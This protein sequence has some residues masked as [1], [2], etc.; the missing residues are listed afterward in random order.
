HGR[1]ASP[2]GHTRSRPKAGPNPGHPV[3]RA[4][5]EAL[6]VLRAPLRGRHLAQ[7]PEELPVHRLPTQAP[8]AVP[9]QA[10]L[11]RKGARTPREPVETV[12]PTHPAAR[13]RV[14]QDVAVPAEKPVGL[15]LGLAEA[16]IPE[17]FE[18]RVR[19]VL[20]VR[21]IDIL[22]NS[23]DPSEPGVDRPPALDP[24]RDDPALRLIEKLPDQRE[25]TAGGIH[26]ACPPN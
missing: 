7:I 6:E 9:E 3:R 24:E 11:F 14:E 23:G 12:L 22:V 13:L 4:A 10:P 16:E 26:G 17:Q 5:A 21:Y 8:D 20:R 25:L 15:R 2:V 1:A 19:S 18:V